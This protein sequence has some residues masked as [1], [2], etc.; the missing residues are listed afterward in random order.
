MAKNLIMARVI[1][2]VE[3]IDTASKKSDFE[4]LIK[5]LTSSIIKQIEEA[6]QI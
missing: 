5:N 3:K 2:E 1:E 4:T 6:L